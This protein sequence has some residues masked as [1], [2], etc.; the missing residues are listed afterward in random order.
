MFES[1]YGLPL[2][3]WFGLA[4]LLV[5][6]PA[7]SIEI[8]RRNVLDGHPFVEALAFGLVRAG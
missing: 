2:G 1:P 8:G 3:L 5:S 4:G 6:G 7:L